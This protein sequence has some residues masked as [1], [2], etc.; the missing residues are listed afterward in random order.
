MA[1]RPRHRAMVDALERRAEERE[2]SVVDYAIEWVGSG[3]SLLDLAAD[4]NTADRL[5]EDYVSRYMVSSYLNG[6]PGGKEGLE[7]ARV[8]GGAG[9]ADQALGIAD[10]ET[11]DRTQVARNKLRSETRLKMAGFLN[12]AYR[13]QKGVHVNLNLNDLHLDALRARPLP[14]EAETAGQLGPGEENAVIE[15]EDA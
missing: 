1:G 5:G 4:I 8:E 14:P 11:D 13:D 2:L 15:G 6:L 3:R 9:L 10:E 7:L 12:P